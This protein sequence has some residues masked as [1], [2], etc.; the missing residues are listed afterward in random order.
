MSCRYCETEPATTHV[1]EDMSLVP[2]CQ[3]CAD[4]TEGDD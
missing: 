3:P 2:V 4:A 1:E